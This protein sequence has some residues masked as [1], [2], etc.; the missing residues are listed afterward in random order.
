MAALKSWVGVVWLKGLQPRVSTFGWRLA[1]NCLPSDDLVRKWQVPLV[2]RCDL[3]RKE[4]ESVHHLFLACEF[5]VKIWTELLMRFEVRWEGF[6]LMEELFSWWKRKARTILLQKAWLPLAILIPYQLWKERNKRRF[7]NRAASHGSVIR[8]VLSSLAEFYMLIPI[9]VRSVSEL[10]LSRSLHLKAQPYQQQRIIELSWAS[11]VQEEVKLN[12]GGC[13]LGNP[14]RTGA[15]GVLRDHE[16]NPMRC[17][18]SYAGVG[19]N[20]YAEFEA[21]FVGIHHAMSLHVENL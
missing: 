4:Q 17:F 14:G 2:S 10:T 8:Q 20:F 21:F 12:I 13:S 15:G 3:C 19:T 6:P 7:E 1:W 11:P 5:S 9:Y 16:G 18:A